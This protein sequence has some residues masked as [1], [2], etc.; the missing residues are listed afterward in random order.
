MPNA[1]RRHKSGGDRGQLGHPLQT[2]LGTYTH[3][4][5]ELR[6]TPQRAAEDLIP[7]GEGFSSPKSPP[8]LLDL[9]DKGRNPR[10][11]R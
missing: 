1:R 10:Q 5:E 7:G 11:F 2:L 3:V 9:R 8:G 6:G 4:I